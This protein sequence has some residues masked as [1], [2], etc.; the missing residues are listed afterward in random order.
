MARAPR[1]MTLERQLK[2]ALDE[3]RLLILGAQ[4]LFGFQFNG[5]FQQLFDELPFVA[6]AL[7]CAG[8]TLI[9]LSL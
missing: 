2:I 7:C 4:V 3:T 1:A 6:R 5:I 8:L 9:M